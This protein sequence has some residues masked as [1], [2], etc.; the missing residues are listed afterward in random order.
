[1]KP[2]IKVNNKTIQNLDQ[3]PDFLKDLLNDKDKNG[4]PDVADSALKMAG[5]GGMLNQ[6]LLNVAGKSFNNIA[7]LSPEDKR[8]LEEKFAKLSKLTGGSANLQSILSAFMNNPG[9]VSTDHP[10]VTVTTSS[11]PIN[12]VQDDKTSS[13]NSIMNTNGMDNLGMSTKKVLPEASRMGQKQTDKYFQSSP[14][15]PLGGGMGSLVTSAKGKGGGAIFLAALVIIISWAVYE[16]SKN[17]VL[18]KIIDNLN[19]L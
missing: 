8:K 4:I 13:I 17:G 3:V 16:L 14:L 6:I 19:K 7:D 1:M 5:N 9:G 11:A 18:E 12:P 15:N 10:M 2:Q